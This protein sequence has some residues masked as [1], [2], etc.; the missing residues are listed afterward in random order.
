MKSS[1]TTT[2]AP[3]ANRR[4]LISQTNNALPT[5]TGSTGT[6]M[7]GKQALLETLLALGVSHVFGNP[8]TTE[9]P[10]MA[11]LT[12][13]PDLHYI[14]GLQE[15]AVMGMADGYARATGRAAF[16][17]IHIA[18]GLGNAM[19]GI[20]NAY[21]GGTPIVVNAGQSDTRMFQEEPFLWSELAQMARPIT[22]WSTEV[23]HPADVPMV[24]AR[25]F[26]V[27][28]EPP[29][30]PVFVSTPWDALDEAAEVEISLSPT[31]YHRARPD[32]AALTQAVELLAR[33]VN[34]LMII[35]DRLAQS[36]GMAEAV[37]LA[38]LLGARVFY[39]NRSEPVFPTDHPLLM[40][41]IGPMSRDVLA[42]ADVLLAVGA[43]LF[44]PFLYTP[45]GAI[46][47]ATR[48][49]Q[50]DS[51]AWE[52]GRVYQPTVGI[53][54][55]PKTVLAELADEL[56]DQFSADNRA[57]A[58]E[59]ARAAGAENAARRAKIAAETKHHWDD[60]PIAPSRLATELARVF[61]TNGLLVDEAITTSPF[62]HDA[63]TFRE[64]GS[65]YSH[66]GGAIG[67][68]PG[69]AVGV[70]I[71]RPERRVIAVL[72]DG[73]T[74]YTLQAFWTAAHYRL[75]VVFVICANH[76]YKVLKV[77]LVKAYG[78]SIRDEHFLGMDLRDPDLSYVKLGEGFG[79]R[80]FHAGE[81]GELRPA[82]EAALATRGPA[83]VEVELD[84]S[85][86]RRSRGA[87]E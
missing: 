43:N 83:L 24:F 15:A 36:G 39:A 6:V 50:I 41:G 51:S 62:L 68:G 76:A 20:F 53:V 30:G 86:S 44:N 2:D 78:E 61:P 7:T 63:F 80:A 85:Y 17:N 23:L 46:T 33:A 34:P 71:A 66:R 16:V 9:S 38:E 18:A 12:D 45:R 42:R 28:E 11:A 59:R 74:T 3:L 35:G 49:I 87:V 10:F 54:A 14:L 56:Q 47:N 81:P 40:G 21:R 4:L 72:G 60:R 8:G 31:R 84:G 64:P 77:N 5:C 26:K 37:R 52:V 29:T 79:L 58:L 55:D 67:W 82:L 65:F 73:A 32:Q 25:A 57:S 69:A 70:Q 75:P 22:K 27:A 19:S 13:Y 1:D 48:L